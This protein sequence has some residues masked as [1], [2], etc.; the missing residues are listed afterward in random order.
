LQARLESEAPRFVSRLEL[1]TE[2]QLGAAADL[3]VAERS[4]D[5]LIAALEGLLFDGE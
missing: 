2:A 4:R 1:C 5:E 3:L